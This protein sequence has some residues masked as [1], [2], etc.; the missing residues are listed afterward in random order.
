MSEPESET[1]GSELLIVTR[2]VAE[3]LDAT[4][5]LLDVRVQ[6]DIPGGLSG[7]PIAI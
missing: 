2:S 3:L 4:I 6:L 5:E 7:K 1:N